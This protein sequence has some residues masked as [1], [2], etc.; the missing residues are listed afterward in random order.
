MSRQLRNPGPR[1]PEHLAEQ[2]VVE[3]RTLGGCLDFDDPAGA[4]QHEVRVGLRLRILGVV[5]IEHRSAGNDA[6]GDRRDTVAQWQPGQHSDLR[7]SLKRLVEGDIAAGHRGGAGTAIGLQYVAVDADLALAQQ[8]EIGD[9][10]QAA[11]D[12]PLNLLRA[13]ALPPARRLAVGARR[14]RTRQHPVLRRDPPLAGV[15]Q[16]RRHALLDRGGAKHMG[17]AELCK[18]GA[19]GVFGDTRFENDRTQRIGGASRG[20]HDAIRSKLGFF[21]THRAASGKEF[22][23]GYRGEMVHVAGRINQISSCAACSHPLST[24]RWL[25]LLSSA[26]NLQRSPPSASSNPY[27]S[28]MIIKSNYGDFTG[29]QGCSDDGGGARGGHPWPDEP[30]LPAR[31]KKRSPTKVHVCPPPF[32][33]GFRETWR[34]PNSCRERTTS[35]SFRKYTSKATGPRVAGTGAKPAKSIRR[36]SSQT[37]MLLMKSPS[38]SPRRP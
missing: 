37:R 15:A 5:Q 19:F 12:Q 18:A 2:R 20:P 14:R 31:R 24:P 28:R 32:S 30:S 33:K 13:S 27:T 34:P 1:E 36:R 26:A 4:G 22:H 7:Q 9:R 25:L 3:R 35:S 21:N 38:A 23:P 16:K 6:A 29:R 11:P 8:R 17:I 10:A